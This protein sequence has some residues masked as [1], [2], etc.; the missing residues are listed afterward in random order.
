MKNKKQ[1]EECVAKNAGTGECSRSMNGRFCI[2]HR[3]QWHRG[4]IDGN[5]KSLRGR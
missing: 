4:I 2:K 1:P 5:G 3:D